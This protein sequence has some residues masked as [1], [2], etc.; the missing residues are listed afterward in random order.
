MAETKTAAPIKGEFIRGTTTFRRWVTKDGS[1]GFKAEAGRYHLYVA[2]NCPWAHRT[3]VLRTYKGL[4]KVISMDIVDRWRDVEKGW[5]FDP[6]VPGTTA[7]TV[8]GCT[9]L[10]EIY[11][12]ADPNYSVRMFA[13]LQL[14]ATSH[15]TCTLGT[16]NDEYY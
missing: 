11:F 8:N 4:E 3:K 7:D 9:Y 15:A 2:N 1:S 5:R 14:V 13:A 6:S 12:L 16:V 10:Q